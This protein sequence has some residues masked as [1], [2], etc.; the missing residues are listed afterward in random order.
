[1]W[2]KIFNS[3]FVE[4]WGVALGALFNPGCLCHW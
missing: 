2:Q 4:K 1:M 3:R